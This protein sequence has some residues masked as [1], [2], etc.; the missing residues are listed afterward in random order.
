MPVIIDEL[1]D[2]YGG[3]FT[4]REVAYE[5]EDGEVLF[6]EHQY[7]YNSTPIEMI[8]DIQEIRDLMEM[9]PVEDMRNI[10]LRNLLD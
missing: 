9:I 10:K 3:N 6:F 1:V 4:Y 2:T 5:I 8:T 7:G